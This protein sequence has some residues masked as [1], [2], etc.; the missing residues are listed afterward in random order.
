MSDLD[1]IEPETAVELYLQERQPELADASLTAHRY[2]L[3][4]LLRWC[5]REGI[6]NLNELTG[7]RIH[8]YRL[9]RRDDGDLNN[10][11]LKTQMDT[12]RVFIRFCERIDAVETGLAE[13]V[14][15]PSLANGENQREVKLDGDA[16]DRILS[17]LSRYRFASFEHVVMRLLWRTGLRLGGSRAIDLSDYHRDENRIRLRHR[18]DQDTPLKNKSDGERLVAIFPETGTIL[19][20]WIDHH[21]PDVTDDYGRQ[22]LLTTEY[23]RASRTTIRET[24]YRVTRPCTYGDCP[25]DRTPADCEATDDH[26][27]LASKCPSSVSPHAV[28]RG[29]IT[30]HLAEDVPEKVVSDR[31]NVGREVLDKHY[32]ERTEQQR[33]EQRRG[34]LDNL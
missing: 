32:D 19:D 29:S 1:P 2:R 25:H 12:V 3:R 20:E 10:V 11:T 34:Y 27:K 4:H 18:P 8:A 31:M 26:R 14:T 21:R 28:R 15:S 13:K 30:H 33:V 7:R 16:A 9:W 22:P 6:E 17:W 5:D 23:G 24:V